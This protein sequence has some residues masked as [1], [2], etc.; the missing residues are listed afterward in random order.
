MRTNYI[1]VVCD[2][3]RE[4]YGI[5]YRK[6]VD[7][8]TT[9]AIP[10]YED[11]Y[12]DDELIRQGWTVTF[13]DDICPDCAKVEHDNREVIK[14]SSGSTMDVHTNLTDDEKI[15]GMPFDEDTFKKLLGKLEDQDD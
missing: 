1:H 4:K 14:F 8:S 9:D 10:D 12:V 2:R 3:C 15:R 13:N 11:K 5:M 7:I 6:S